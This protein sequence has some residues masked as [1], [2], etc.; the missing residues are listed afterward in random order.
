MARAFAFLL[1]SVKNG[2][3][4]FYLPVAPRYFVSEKAARTSSAGTFCT[5]S[6]CWSPQTLILSAINIGVRGQRAIRNRKGFA[7]DPP[8]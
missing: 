3:G 4:F 8:F 1:I 6:E 2:L 5:T 7:A